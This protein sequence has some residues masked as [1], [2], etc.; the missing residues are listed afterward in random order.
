MCIRDSI[1]TTS[2]PGGTKTGTY[3]QNLAATGGTTPLTWSLTAG[4][5]P[6]GL[7]L[8]ASTGVISGTVSASASR[9]V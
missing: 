6:T 5:L 9:C 8:N 7:T 1:T 2:L 3:S 4:S